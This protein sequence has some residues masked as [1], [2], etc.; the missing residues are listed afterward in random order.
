MALGPL[1]IFSW[2]CA[3]AGRAATCG[4][5]AGL[6]TVGALWLG[7]D[8]VVLQALASSAERQGRFVCDLPEWDALHWGDGAITV[9]SNKIWLHGTVLLGLIIAVPRPRI[10]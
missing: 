2:V 7:L 9:N 8:Q 5:I 1:A 6:D 4:L 10:C 3:K